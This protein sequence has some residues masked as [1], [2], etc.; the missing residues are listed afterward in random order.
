MTGPLVIG[1]MVAAWP[2]HT[3]AGTALM[4]ATL[5]EQSRCGVSM[6]VLARDARVADWYVDQPCGVQ[7]NPAHPLHI[8]WLNE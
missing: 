8:A 5:T 1:S 4:Q 3:G 7:V 6:L 2:Q